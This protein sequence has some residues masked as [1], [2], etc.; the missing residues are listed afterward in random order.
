MAK[1]SIRWP[2]FQFQLKLI[3]FAFVNF[4]LVRDLY[5]AQVGEESAYPVNGKEIRVLLPAEQGSEK[6]E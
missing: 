6:M 5:Q 3:P 1:P 2:F 4:P